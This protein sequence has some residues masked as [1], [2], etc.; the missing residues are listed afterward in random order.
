MSL[1]TIKKIIQNTPKIIK[2]SVKEHLGPEI[3]VNFEFIEN[4]DRS[5]SGKLLV[6][7]SE[8]AKKRFS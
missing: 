8:C 7:E 5:K 3:K 2:K 1:G 6:V 4:I